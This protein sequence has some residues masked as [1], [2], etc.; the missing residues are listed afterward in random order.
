MTNV[1]YSFLELFFSNWRWVRKLSKG[2]WVRGSCDWVKFNKKELDD[3]S[4]ML[5]KSMQYV[6]EDYTDR[7]GL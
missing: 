3:V 6:I 1:T 7:R 4:I 2:F 5:M